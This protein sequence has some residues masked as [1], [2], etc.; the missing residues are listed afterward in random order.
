MH[1]RSLLGATL[2]L[3]LASVSAS[4]QVEP[5]WK[6]KEGD[7]FFLQTN[8]QLRQ[9]TKI[10]QETVI[11]EDTLT[12][13]RFKV[14]KKDAN[15]LVFEKTILARKV[16]SGVKGPAAG[17]ATEKSL[18]EKHAEISKKIEGSACTITMDANL[19]KV[20]DVQ[21]VDEFV[22]RTFGDKPALEKT[23]AASLGARTVKEEVESVFCAFLP[24]VPVKPGDTWKRKTV[25]SFG[26]MGEFAADGRYTYRGDDIL[27]GQSLNRIDVKWAL[28]YVPPG[29]NS[30]LPYTIKSADLKTEKAEGAYLFDATTGRLVQF[31]RN[32]RVKGTIEV[33]LGGD[34]AEMNIESQLTTTYRLLG[35]NPERK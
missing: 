22:A 18:D 33:S 32:V 14:L 3:G 5:S 15:R 4:G 26:A 2:A 30:G 27:D 13:E 9:T 35:K 12:V 31:Q 1:L 23:L 28:N 8:N 25:I 29:K 10:S 11:S 7:Q 17:S 6:L 19:G 24:G 34:D 21:G 16:K 20:I